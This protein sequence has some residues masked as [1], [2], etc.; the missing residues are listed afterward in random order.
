MT[1]ESFNQYEFNTQT[2][3]TEDLALTT[4]EVDSVI[5]ENQL[6]DNTLRSNSPIRKFLRKVFKG[7]N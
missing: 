1:T 3:P 2:I 7:N 5:L 4:E 6:K